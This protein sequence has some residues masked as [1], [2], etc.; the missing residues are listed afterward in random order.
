MR[1]RCCDRREG[2][3]EPAV[4][5]LARRLRGDERVVRLLQGLELAHQLVVLAVADQRLVEDVV[6][7]GVP[8]ELLGQ[9]PVA[10]PRGLGDLGDVLPVGRGS[11][12]RG[13]E[14]GGFGAHGRTVSGGYDGQPGVP[15]D[16]STSSR[17]RSAARSPPRGGRTC[18]RQLTPGPRPPVRWRRRRSTSVDVVGRGQEQPQ[19]GVAHNIAPT[20][21]S[22]R[23]QPGRVAIEAEPTVQNSRPFP[24][25]EGSRRGRRPGSPPRHPCPRPPHRRRARPPAAS[26]PRSATPGLE[27][28]APPPQPVCRRRRGGRSCGER[29]ERSPR[30]AVRDRRV[31]RPSDGGRSPCRRAAARTPGRRGSDAGATTTVRRPRTGI[32]SSSR[33]SRGTSLSGRRAAHSWL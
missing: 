8:V 24:Q 1:S 9:L 22:P 19:G 7:E 29:G 4:D 3:G 10:G 13:V 30:R 25:A 32:S 17:G 27:P 14:F 21:F 33:V 18:H 11:D 5:L 16:G 28:R 23:Y 31:R 26:E 20:A 6:G 15:P 12:R 2:R